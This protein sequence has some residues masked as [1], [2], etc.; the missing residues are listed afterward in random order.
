MT[1]R[2]GG[3]WPPFDCVIM[4]FCEAYPGRNVGF[5]VEG[6]DDDFGAGGE[7]EHKGEVGKE[8]GC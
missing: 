3:R 6:G 2:G 4:Q 8:L 1:R 5:V 7:V